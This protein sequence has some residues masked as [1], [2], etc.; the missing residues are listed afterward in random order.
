MSGIRT[1]GS[2][3]TMVALSTVNHWDTCCGPSLLNRNR[4][5]Y[6]PCACTGRNYTHGRPCVYI[7]IETSIIICP[8][9]GPSPEDADNQAI[10]MVEGQSANYRRWSVN[11]RRP[12]SSVFFSMTLLSP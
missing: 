10:N 6:W 3:A 4:P 5:A 12:R 2:P 7:H 9:C 1:Y 11:Y 8:S